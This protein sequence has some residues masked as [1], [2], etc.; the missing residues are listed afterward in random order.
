MIISKCVGC[1]KLNSE[2]RKT[3]PVICPNSGM[4]CFAVLPKYVTMES[5]K[6]NVE[7]SRFV[8]QEN[9]LEI[10]D[11]LRGIQE[12]QVKNLRIP[13]NCKYIDP[14]FISTN[15]KVWRELEEQGDNTIYIMEAY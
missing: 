12:E 6:D 3:L 11:L 10:E 9:G 8:L 15:L 2:N 4:P 13:M 1:V 7:Y 5:E 14:N